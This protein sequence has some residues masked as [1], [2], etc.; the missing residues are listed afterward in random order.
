[1]AKTTDENWSVGK[2]GTVITDSIEGFKNK[3]GH[4]GEDAKKYYGGTLICESVWREKD[5]HLISAA[6]DMLRALENLENDANQI[7]KHAWDM[8]Q[9]AIKKAI[10]K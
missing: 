8:V 10:N 5:S 7:P 1:M 9:S 6:P 4:S 3:T 2:T